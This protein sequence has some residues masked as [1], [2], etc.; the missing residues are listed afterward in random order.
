MKK[1]KIFWGI[2]FILAA[3]IVV[4]SRLGMIPDVGV[5][6]ILATAFLIWVFVEG[7]RNLN[8][9][10]SLFSLAF[11]CIIH[12]KLLGIE[13]LTPWTVLVAAL[14]LSIGLSMLF[15]GKRK[16]SHSIETDWSSRSNI[17]S[18]EQCSDEHVYCKNIFGVAIRYINS[19]NFCN[20]YLENSFGST[21]VYFDNAVI[22]GALADVEIKNS[23]GETVL[24][25]PKEW[26]VQKDLKQSFGSVEESGV[27]V[28]SSSVTI[29][30]HGETSFGSIEIHYV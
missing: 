10:A 3:V 16:K 19:D 24:Y 7:I 11:I 21:S 25:I 2:F 5:F 14:L 17:S 13:A 23:F 8:F 12:D 26:K 18:S 9:F 4:I 30:V 20:A 28:G 1:S 22:Q 15:Q 27:C 29:Y 6:S